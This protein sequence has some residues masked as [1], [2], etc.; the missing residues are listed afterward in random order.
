MGHT[1]TKSCWLFPGQGT[2]RRGMGAA[3][4]DAFPGLVKRA[5]AILGY[6][7]RA[8]CLEDP[9]GCLG[10]TEFCQ[11]ALFVVNALQF[12]HLRRT[13]PWPDFVAGHSLGE[14]SALFAAGVFDFEAGLAIVKARAAHMGAAGRG[15]MLAV[16]GLDATALERRIAELGLLDLDIANY[17]LPDQTVVAGP[18]PAIA[19]LDEEVRRIG[20]TRTVHLHIGG[21]FH[22]RYA[23]AAADDFRRALDGFTLHDPKICVVSGVTGRPIAPGAVRD[24]LACQILQPVKWLEVMLYLRAQGVDAARQVGPGRVLDGLW[25][26]FIQ[27]ETGEHPETGGALR[28]DGRG[29]DNLMSKA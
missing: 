17:N 21:A 6:S 5:D 18:E 13:E 8:I 9:G 7:V 24:I 29:A 15:G 27:P 25:R 22:S 11:P 2:Q 26:R 19:R 28:T 4:F 14:Y 23:A 1:M 12:L 3:L 20:G 10:R 16:I